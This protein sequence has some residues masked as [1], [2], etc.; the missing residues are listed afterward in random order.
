MRDTNTRD[1]NLALACGHKIKQQINNAALITQVE[2][3][4]L[5]AEAE[6]EQFRAQRQFLFSIVNYTAVE[7]AHC[8]VEDL[9]DRIQH[10]LV[11]RKV[12]QVHPWSVYLDN[13][14]STQYAHVCNYA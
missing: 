10:E 11:M 13:M 12:R 4:S 7:T 6:A 9:R 2:T 8:Q 3:A 14:Y 5:V 1:P